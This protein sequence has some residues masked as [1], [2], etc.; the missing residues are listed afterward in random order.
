MF[1]KVDYKNMGRVNYG[2]LN[3]YFYFFFVNYYNLN[4][5]NFGVLCVINDDLVVV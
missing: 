3:I 2:W 4:N 5:M 1:R